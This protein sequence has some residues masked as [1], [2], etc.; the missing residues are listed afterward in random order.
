M[1]FW[2]MPLADGGSG[3][4]C[5]RGHGIKGSRD[6][7]SLERGN[8][9]LGGSDLCRF[10]GLIRL[11]DSGAASLVFVLRKLIDVEVGTAVGLSRV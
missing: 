10:R 1:L 9:G 5:R 8:R 4:S 3:I 7:D 6:A 11:V 2:R